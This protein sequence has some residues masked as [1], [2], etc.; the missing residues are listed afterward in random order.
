MRFLKYLLPFV[1]I[2]GGIL[3][4][5]PTAR[6]FALVVIGRSP[7]CPLERALE[8]GDNWKQQIALKDKILAASR[9]IETD[10]EGFMRW[11]TPR[12]RFWIPPDNQWVLPFNLAEQERGIY[13]HENV[14]I[15]P[16]DIVL[17]CGANVGVF[18]REALRREAAVVVAIE[19]SPPNIEC[20][21]RNFRTEIRSGR[22][23]VYTKGLWDEEGELTLH[24]DP[25]N[26]AADS[27]VIQHGDAHKEI[28]VP[29]TTIDRMMEELGLERV[30]FIKM[31]IE[32]AEVR[33][34]RGGRQTIA[35][36]RPR[37]SLSVYHEPSHPV[38]VPRAVFA[39]WNGYRQICGPCAQAGWR[40]RPDIFYFY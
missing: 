37:M 25:H 16:G 21:R 15:R 26:T 3:Y 9:K 31:D 32:G 4:F 8:S 22:V 11:E 29:V 30:D 36:F 20:L 28:Q 1:A 12:G 17:D 35:R 7:H 5:A 2:L 34:L 6:L 24:M 18:T 14:Q 38:E 33:A 19:P 13:W 40:I 23:I 10:E 39:A 27:L